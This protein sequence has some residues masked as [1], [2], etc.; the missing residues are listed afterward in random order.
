MNREPPYSAY[1]SSIRGPRDILDR[2]YY[3]LLSRK[4]AVRRDLYSTTIEST[5]DNI[6]DLLSKEETV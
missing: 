2:H 5:R 6:E 4:A 3:S 1:N